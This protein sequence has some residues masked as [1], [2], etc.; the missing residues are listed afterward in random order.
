M[1]LAWTWFLPLAL[2]GA[3][4]ILSHGPDLPGGLALPHPWDKL[5]HGSAF[6]LL[7]LLLEIAFRATA[8]GMPRHR[9][10]VWIF[11]IAGLFALLDEW[12][13]S[14]VPGREPSL[15]DLA[16]DAFGILLGA[17]LADLPLI[18]TRRLGGLSWR[19]G[20]ARRPDP[21]RPLILVADAHWGEELT[22]LR[23]ATLRHPEADWLFLGDVFDVWIGLEGMETESQRAFLWWVRERRHAGRWVGL[24]LGNR[25]F[26]L[27]RHA[28][29]FDCLWEG[30]GGALAGERLHFE[31]G[32]LVNPAD[33][34]Y[35]VW[36]LLSRG[37][38]VW[39]LAKS[40][41]GSLGRRL[42]ER[43]ERALR[44]TNPD[45]RL[46]FP[47]EAFRRAAEAHPDATFLTGHFHVQEVEGRGRVLP[48]VRSGG[49][50]VW[51]EGR[52]EPL[53]GPP[54]GP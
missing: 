33:R 29:T 28:R 50:W 37:L 25:E 18:F 31:H 1:T 54:P 5:A 17:G 3:M 13:Q 7:A 21:S 8:Q 9:R 16:A 39:S 20:H 15:G 24:C 41:S 42:A 36:N 11:L 47:R 44:T 46:H 10:R 48:W 34:M 51:R 26:F 27:E 4:T 53:D 43:L 2:M 49:F 45:H 14:F 30:T 23:E 32:D 38:L 52:V 22:G 12:H 35:R 6:A 19:R 40:L